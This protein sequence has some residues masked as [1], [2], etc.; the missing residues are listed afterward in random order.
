LNSKINVDVT[1][2]EKDGK[3]EFGLAFIYLLDFEG[4]KYLFALLIVLPKLNH[5][6]NRD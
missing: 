4:N 2:K 6:T 1:Y 3:F 5:Y